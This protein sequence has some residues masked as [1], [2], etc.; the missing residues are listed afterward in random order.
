MKEQQEGRKRGKDSGNVAKDD[1]Y[2]DEYWEKELGRDREREKDCER[3][4]EHDRS[5]GEDRG[6]AKKVYQE[7]EIRAQ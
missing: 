4:R 7:R 1:D 2:H 5:K 3:G 6:P